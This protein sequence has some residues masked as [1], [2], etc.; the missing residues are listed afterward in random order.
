MGCCV[1][2]TAFFKLDSSFSLPLPLP[3]EL[4]F[5]EPISS[6][7]NSS[8]SF[9]STPCFYDLPC[10]YIYPSQLEYQVFF[11]KHS[12]A[13]VIILL[14][15]KPYPVSLAVRT[16]YLFNLT[17][18]YLLFIHP[19]VLKNLLFLKYNQHCFSS[20]LSLSPLF[21]MPSPPFSCLFYISKYLLL[22]TSGGVFLKY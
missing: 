18:H 3:R 19:D 5:Q 22:L 8:K 15:I 1:F 13:H 16:L 4:L 2:S 17:S 7:S 10:Q 12:I 6:S 11:L 14:K 21:H 20:T 9:Q